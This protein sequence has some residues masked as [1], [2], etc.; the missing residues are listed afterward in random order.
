MNIMIID[1][2]TGVTTTT[3]AILED[4]GHTVSVRFNALGTMAKIL[5]ER[6]QLLLLDLE[7]PSLNGLQLAKIVRQRIS[8]TIVILYSGRSEKEL[9]A[10]ARECGAQGWL[11]KGA[12][13][14]ALI[15]YVARFAS[16]SSQ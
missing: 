2:D 9:E 15:D 4:A 10:L 12:S 5:K 1:D 13:P 6:P 3:Q 8:D 16:T 14:S 7:M 11:C